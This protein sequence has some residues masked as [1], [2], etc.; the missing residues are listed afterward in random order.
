MSGGGLEPRLGSEGDP[1]QIFNDFRVP[2]GSH[3]GSVFG[4][5]FVFFNVV[6]QVALD[7][8]F[9]LVSKGFGH[10]KLKL[11]AMKNVDFPL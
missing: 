5:C 6:L 9:S 11:S 3:F 7:I 8:C 4:D 2:L 1:D 10:H